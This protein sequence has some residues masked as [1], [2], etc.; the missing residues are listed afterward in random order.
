LKATFS[1]ISFAWFTVILLM[2]SCGQ[3][4]PPTGGPRDSIPPILVGADPAD[5][6]TNFTGKRITLEF[7][8]YIQLENPF[9]KLNYSPVPKV[10]PQAEGRLKT[11]TIRIKDTLEP[12][13]TY[14]IDFGDA[15]KDINE[16]NVLRDLTYVFST[17]PKIDSGIVSGQVFIAETGKTD[18]TLIVVLHRNL[19]DSAVAKEKPRYSARVKSNGEFVLKYLA[20]GEYRIFALKDADGGMKFDQQSEMIGFLDRTVRADQ[21]EPVT[22]YAFAPK[23]EIKKA[24]ATGSGQ[25]ANRN[26]DDKRIKFNTSLEGGRQDLLSELVLTFENKLVTY[27][28]ARFAFLDES[29]KPVSPVRL[30]PDSTRRKLLI[31]HPWT[32]DRK[33][34]II[35]QR[36]FAKD[37]LGYS[38]TRPDTISFQAKKKSDYGSLIIRFKNVDTALHPVLQLYRDDQPERSEPIRLNRYQYDLIRPGEYVIRILYDKNGNGRWDTGDYW[39]KI[40]PE[41]VVSR[42]D[43]LTVRA[44]WDNE[45]EID[46]RE[47][48]N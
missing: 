18:S 15:I 46:L 26:K 25:P 24:P 39:K 16:N 28:T 8:E 43:K 20:P 19:D 23:E 42:K 7:N 32:E 34:K 33:Y 44:N 17:G 4:L 12:N 29:F 9:E 2:M 45:L 13:T 30:R 47:I 27:D 3:P 10:R 40:Q 1:F 31:N 36:D 35:L 41:R 6:A 38:F 48:G 5:S 14:S 11:V 37:T 22:L 21:P